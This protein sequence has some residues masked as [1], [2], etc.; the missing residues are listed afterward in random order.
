MNIVVRRRALLVAAKVALSVTVMGCSA[1]DRSDDG[2][3]VTSHI[4]SSEE[5]KPAEKGEG[6]DA[7]DGGTTVAKGDAGADAGPEIPPWWEPHGCTLGE[8]FRLT[9]CTPWGPPMPPV[10]S[11]AEVA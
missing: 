1:D 5:G 6:K 3:Q 11:T 10:M 4:E 9:G 8:D 7:K 2:S